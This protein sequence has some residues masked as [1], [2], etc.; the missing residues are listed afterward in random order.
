MNKRSK[1]RVMT[2]LAVLSCSLVFSACVNQEQDAAAPAEAE[3]VM[4][5]ETAQTAAEKNQMAP[6][7]QASEYPLYMEMPNNLKPVECGGCHYN[8][9][10]K[11]Q[12]SNSKHRFDCLDCHEQLHGNIPSKNNY[13]DV[14][15][16][17][18]NCHD[19]PHGEAFPSCSQCHQ[20]PH[21]PLDIPFSGVEQSI[22]N[23]AGKDVVACEVC[24]YDS[25]GK[26]METYPNKH[27]VDVGC[28]GCHGDEKHGV[29]PTC[30]KCHEPHVEGQIYADCLVC[31]RPHSAKKIL[32]Y[33]EEISNKVC[34]SCH[35]GIYDSLQANVTKHTALQ[36]ASCHVTHGQIPRCQGCHDEPHGS[37]VHKRFP[38]CLEC[39]VD[40][41][42]LPV[43]PKA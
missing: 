6:E 1:L 28:T 20:N 2:G 23:H 37:A 35:T 26:E 29:R 17:C 4:A 36:C 32:P 25:E 42:N 7:N 21:S 40:P 27:N 43:K 16:Q 13:K 41:H 8:Q 18:A 5:V 24:H 15:P 38:N 31:H 22:K 12:Q 30:F 39:H 19:L 34:A 10:T 9:Y 11:V 33:P 14:L 3:Q